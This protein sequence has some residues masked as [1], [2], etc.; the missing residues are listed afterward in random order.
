MS[1]HKRGLQ[2]RLWCP[3]CGGRVRSLVSGV[4]QDMMGTQ[5][6][7]IACGKIW[8]VSQNVCW[9]VT[10]VAMVLT[11]GG[12]A[13]CYWGFESHRDAD[14]MAVLC[15]I[16]C[17]FIVWPLLYHLVWKMKIRK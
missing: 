10:V 4:R 2:F 12:T 7:C 11:L 1:R 3:K 6:N 8:R 14:L 9:I 5:R 16:V 13:A 17:V 15:L